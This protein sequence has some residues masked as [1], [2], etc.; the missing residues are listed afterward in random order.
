MKVV[1]DEFRGHDVLQVG[2]PRGAV[3]AEDGGAQWGARL[4]QP[5]E[6]A[7]VSYWVR[8]APGFKFAL[9]GKLP[10]LIGGRESGL[11]VAG[12]I[13]PT[14]ENGWSARLM[15][16]EAGQLVQYVYHM[17]QKGKYGD[18]IPWLASGKAALLKPGSWHH[19]ES[20]ITLN[21][22]A[23]ADGRIRSWFDGQLVLDRGDF[24]F[25]SVPTIQIDTLFF[26]TFFGGETPDWVPLRDEWV[27]FDGFE[28]R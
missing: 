1:R 28:V 12:G 21:A 23:K 26:S 25:R 8:F 3:G 27:R 13:R 7:K 2:Y 5:R 18:Q 9:G 19:L 22:P 15:W 10:G 20:E 4:T 6:R 11:P 24:R 17:D 16:L 14:G